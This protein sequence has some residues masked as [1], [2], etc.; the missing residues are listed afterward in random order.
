[1]SN[2][3]KV[4]LSGACSALAAASLSAC[5]APQASSAPP[6]QLAGAAQSAAAPSPGSAAQSAAPLETAAEFAPLAAAASAAGAAASPA[7]SAGTSSPAAARADAKPYYYVAPGGSDKTGT[8]AKDRPWQT[9]Q[10]AANEAAKTGGTVYARKGVYRQ[11]L[12]LA[13]L[14]PAGSAPRLTVASYPSE[15]AVLDGTGLPV[16]G[17]EGLIEL[18]NVSRVTIRGFELRG[19]KTAARDAVPI[20]IYVRGAGD[21]IRLLDNKVHAVAN[22]AAPAGQGLT[23][24]DA[25]GIAVYGT[26][27]QASIRNLTIAGNEVYNLTLGTS[28]AVVLNGN[29]EKFTVENN[30]VHDND[31]IGIDAIGFEGTSPNPQTDQARGGIIRGNLVTGSTSDRNPSY[32]RRIPNGSH[33]AGGIYIDGGRDIVVERN[34][35]LRNDIGVEIASEH[36]GRSTSN[37]TV[38]SNLLARN[39]LTGLAMGGYDEER[40]STTNSVVTGNT[41]AYNDTLE[42]GTGQLYIQF[43][44]R[45]NE[46]RNNI[47]AAS[48]TNELIVN[49][50]AQNTNNRVDYNLYFTRDAAEAVW[51]WKNKTYTGFADYRKGTGSD[52]HSVFAAPMFQNAAKDDYR[53]KADSP[54]QGKGIADAVLSASPDL[55]GNKR[56]ASHAGRPSL[57]AYE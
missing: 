57:G 27:A 31:N 19:Y 56:G 42:W 7:G 34:R 3:L 21:D 54:A 24:R 36:A 1:M 43:D 12:K 50:Y 32:G 28:E 48:G 30:Y 39:A 22:T 13:D 44:T 6:A 10:R 38:R 23:G 45:G 46:I 11:Q 18:D 40:G 26:E 33:S 16:D 4:I 25:H 35:S 37:I 20:G 52:A 41:I 49:E 29:V 53:L 51:M 2:I 5:A 47:F 17:S 55:A 14:K 8:G 15:T 9:L